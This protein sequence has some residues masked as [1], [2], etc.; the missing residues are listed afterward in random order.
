MV[1]TR[2]GLSLARII[3]VNCKGE[4]VLDIIVKP[5]SPVMDYNTRFSGLT[6]NLVD[7]TIYDFKQAR[8]R[9]LEFVNSETILI[10]HSLASDLKALRI[11]HHKIVDTSDVFPHERGPPYKRSLKNIFSDIFHMKIQEKN[12]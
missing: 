4:T 11:V 9:F 12:G 6:K 3:L 7:A 8:E 2:R 1:Y 5:E 10:G